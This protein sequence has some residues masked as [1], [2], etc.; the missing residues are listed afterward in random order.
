M[1]ELFSFLALLS[2]NGLARQDGGTL[3]AMVL[4]QG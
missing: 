2:L 1:A 4:S 3:V